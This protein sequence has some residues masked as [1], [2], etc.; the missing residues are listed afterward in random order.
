MNFDEVMDALE[1]WAREDCNS[2]NDYEGWIQDNLTLI[3]VI[4][5]N[6]LDP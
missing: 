6:R 4:L 1:E 5:R 2:P 3:A